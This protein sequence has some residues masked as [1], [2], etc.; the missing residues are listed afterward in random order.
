MQTMHAAGHS[1]YDVEHAWSPL[2]LKLTGVTMLIVLAGE[3]CPPC[4]Q[5][6]LFDEQLHE[7][8][9]RVFDDAMQLL[10]AYWNGVIFDGYPVLS[11]CVPCGDE[12]MTFDNFEDLEQFMKAGV[13]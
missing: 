12:P 4:Q 11:S 6:G 8:Q 13:R 3:T 1:R 9:I 2:S 7:K 10:N 5:A